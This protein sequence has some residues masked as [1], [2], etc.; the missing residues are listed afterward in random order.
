M[1][2]VLPQP[3][4]L[5]SEHSS[6][7]SGSVLQR[8]RK[9][10]VDSEFESWRK[11]IK[12]GGGTQLYFP[13]RPLP[14]VLAPLHPYP[15]FACHTLRP[16]AYS[17]PPFFLSCRHFNGNYW[18]ALWRSAIQG[19]YR[20]FLSVLVGWGLVEVFRLTNQDEPNAATM[21]RS[22]VVSPF[23]PPRFQVLGVCK[24]QKDDWTLTGTMT[25]VSLEEIFM[26]YWCRRRDLENIACLSLLLMRVFRTMS[27]PISQVC[28]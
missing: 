6:R 19:G 10:G 4:T 16:A 12:W 3:K 7:I 13:A 18:S 25:A 11:A 15:G 1:L 22:N 17:H 14:R 28:E 2:S 8:A 24:K 27:S 5:A 26:N 9:S 23:G 20:P 21:L